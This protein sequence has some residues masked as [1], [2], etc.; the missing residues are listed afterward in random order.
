MEFANDLLASLRDQVRLPSQGAQVPGFDWIGVHA[1]LAAGHAA[2]REMM[3]GDSPA[4][5]P[6][7][8]FADWHSAQSAAGNSLPGV[9]RTDLADIKNPEGINGDSAGEPVAGGRG[10]E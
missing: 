8:G 6:R 2:R 3:R 10:Q 7:G 4:A 9:N 5:K 1:R